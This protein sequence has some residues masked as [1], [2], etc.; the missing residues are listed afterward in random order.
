L[1]D[2]SDGPDS[3][4]S[5]DRSA[6]PGK[7]RRKRH[8]NRRAS[9][10]PPGVAP[11]PAGDRALASS[12]ASLSAGLF[13]HL[14][15]REVPCRIDGCRNTWTWSPEEQIRSFGQPPP[16]RTCAEHNALFHAVA[17][18]EVPCSREGCERTWTWTKA[19]QLAIVQRGGMLDPPQRPCDACRGARGSSAGGEADVAEPADAPH[20]IEVSCKVDGCKRT[21]TWSRDAQLKHRAWL[22]HGARPG[23]AG[24]HGRGG[25]HRRGGE[26][27]GHPDRPPP[28][29][30]E[31]CHRKLAMLTD[32]EGSC[33]V[34]GCTRTATIDRD[35]QLRA[36]AAL[37]TDDLEV[38]A[39]LPKRMCESC[40]EFCRLHPDREVP[41]GRPGCGRS[42]TYK[43]GAQLQAFLAG[44]FDDPSRLC[45][46]CHKG[47]P[48]ALDDGVEVEPGVEIMPCIVPAC[49]GTWRW[50]A[51]ETV[52]PCHDGEQPLDRM[53][54][55]CRAER[56]AAPSVQDPAP[57]VQDHDPGDAPAEVS[58]TAGEP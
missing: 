25:R 41:C 57:S 42:W 10:G 54:A 2:D 55:N 53:C 13:S 37:R 15:A 50:R 5:D 11:P 6:P 16:R 20:D 31:P 36:W 18:R 9:S 34:H 29:M 26:G 47:A 33:R 22:R 38:E 21:W 28:R 49:D 7:R 46:T 45:E 3:P 19:A 4:A 23:D 14:D 40:R 52:A 44:R 58:S 51:G 12:F 39:P 1:E 43:T 17:D 48:A 56:G 8:R 35:A 32:R 24:P 27:R 30:C